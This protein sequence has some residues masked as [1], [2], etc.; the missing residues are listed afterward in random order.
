MSEIKFD[1]IL[2]HEVFNVKDVKNGFALDEY[3][4]TEG[5]RWQF[6][7]DKAVIEE[8]DLD[9]ENLKMVC[10]RL[11]NAKSI[12]S[13]DRIAEQCKHLFVGSPL[14]NSVEIAKEVQDGKG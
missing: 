10:R 1:E 8:K 14:R 3:S 2:V 11:S 7:Q 13:R 4:F 5:A 9:I 12:E 6:E